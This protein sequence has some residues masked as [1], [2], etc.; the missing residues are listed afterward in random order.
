MNEGFMCN[1]CTH[2]TIVEYGEGGKTVCIHVQ[3]TRVSFAVDMSPEDGEELANNLLRVV[4][5]AKMERASKEG[6]E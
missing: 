2:F 3:T 1:D 5:I 6:S 4:G